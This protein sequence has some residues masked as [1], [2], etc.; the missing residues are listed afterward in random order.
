LRRL[1]IGTRGS[2]LALWQA[3]YVQRRLLEERGIIADIV[4]IKTAGDHFQG[5]PI[6]ALGL[7]G[8]F[9]K[10]IEDALLDRRVDLAVHSLKDV[11]TEVSGEFAFPAFC[12]RQDPRDSLISAGGLP[13]ARL[14]S[15]SRV[16]TSSLRRRAQ[17]RS[18][19][20]DLDFQELRG[21]VD[22]RLRKLDAGE[23]DAIVLAKAGLERLG[24]T[25][26]I[27]EVLSPEVC[28]PA[29]GQGA[30][31]LETLAASEVCAAVSA[32][33][34]LPTRM[35][36]AAERALLAALQGG[37]QVPV[38][39]WARMNDGAIEVDAAVFSPD[40]SECI[41]GR[42]SGRP[43]DAVGVGHRLA[44]ELLAKGAAR[45]L[46]LAGRDTNGD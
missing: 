7:K 18:S 10:E 12:E 30:I 1:R 36:A 43:E 16:G 27:S 33:D 25:E 35:C 37:C 2:P 32:L 28:L 23:C 5:A 4:V 24:L 6:P 38:G 11:P 34:H 19:R 15:G 45:L 29:V 21:N 40:G 8:V 26:R 17:L 41:R 3:E 9:I 39:A 22:T 42:G 44:D 14:A 31:V 20:T 13:F 46:A